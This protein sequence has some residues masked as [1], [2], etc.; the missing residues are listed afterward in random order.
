MVQLAQK[1]RLTDY[2]ALGW[3]TMVGVGWLVLM[4]DW[5]TRGGPLG[6]MLGFALG[7]PLL[8]PIAYVYGK[9]VAR[10][11][12]AAGEVAYT[13]AVFPR[14]FSFA[15]GWMMVLAYFIVCPWEAVAIGRIAAYIFPALDQMELYRVGGKP[16]FLPHLVIGLALTV[17]LTVMNYRGVRLSASFQNWASFAVL[18]LSAVFAGGGI[19]RGSVQNALPLFSHSGFISVLLVLQVVPYFMTGFESVAKCSE[20]ATLE[21]RGRNFF[22]AMALAVVVAAVFYVVVIGA[23]AVAAPWK[24]IVGERF[25]TAVALERALGAGW[26]VRVILAAALL[27][28]CKCFNGNFVASS[29]LVFALGRRGLVDSRLAWVH[30]ENRTPATAVVWVGIAT[31]VAMLLGQAILVPISEVGSAAAALGWTAACAAYF[32]MKPGSR[33]R[34]IAVVGMTVGLLMIAMKVA[35]LVPGHFDQWEWIALGLWCGLGWL[36]HVTGKRETA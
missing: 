30:P 23:V 27:S 1:L 11:P 24:E 5:L 34:A 33:Q 28:L 17:L 6:G 32:C 8:L 13:A 10:M 25:M 31:A 9:L 3:G 19:L 15:T 35:P 2:F 26:I 18:A 22:T 21:F 4:D 12:D 20:E 29:R 36:L 7:I 14:W 16:I